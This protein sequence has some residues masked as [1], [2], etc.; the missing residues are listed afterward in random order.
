MEKLNEPAPTRKTDGPGESERSEGR[1]SIVE[2]LKETGKERLANE[3]QAAAEQAEKLAN[4]VE[5]A[6]EELGRGDFVS[7]AGYANQLAAKMK[8]FAGKLHD[9]S[10]ED[11]VDETR[12][13]ARRNP[14][15]FL[16]GSIAVGVAL[17]RFFKA[18]EQHGLEHPAS[19]LGGPTKR[20]GAEDRLAGL[21]GHRDRLLVHEI[22]YADHHHVRVGMV[23]GHRHVGRRFR[24]APAI[25]ERVAAR[26]AP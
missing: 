11:L 18:S 9:I 1:K 8:R 12:R 7:I 23:D 5:R 22:R 20:L 21:R 14:E 19:L 17:S 24:D 6:T 13:A 15:L 2:N 10:I 16:L 26:L 3:K 4:V 25:A